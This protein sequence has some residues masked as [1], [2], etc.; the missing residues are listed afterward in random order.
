MDLNI[1]LEEALIRNL[2][3]PQW[4]VFVKL[5]VKEGDFQ[6]LVHDNSKP[7]KTKDIVF[8]EINNY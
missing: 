6:H 1:Q 2:L 5:F 7:K 3:K 4:K 8:K